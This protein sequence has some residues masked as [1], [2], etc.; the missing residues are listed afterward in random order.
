MSRPVKRSV[1]VSG[2]RTSVT[3]EPEFW[4]ELAAI[5]ARRGLSVNALVSEIDRARQPGENLS[6]S[7]RVHVLRTL[8]GRM[9]DG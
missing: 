1:L 4:E 9:P 8:R 3:L 6:S 7:L 5:A 2:H